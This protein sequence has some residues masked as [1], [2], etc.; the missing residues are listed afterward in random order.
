MEPTP[1]ATVVLARPAPAHSE[2]SGPEIL[3]MKRPASMQF[4]A[5]Y[6][7]FPGGALH[8]EDSSEAA[9]A[10]SVLSEAQAQERMG[11]GAGGVDALPFYV[12]AL[13]ELFEETG[14]L[15]AIGPPLGASELRLMRSRV[16][17]GE[18]FVKLL[19]D[20]EC[21]LSTDKIFYHSRWRAPAALPIRFDARVFVAE[22]KGEPLLGSEAELFEWRSCVEIMTLAE[23]GQMKLAP[24][25]AATVSSL[26]AH[27]T[28]ANMLAPRAGAPTLPPATRHSSLV[29]RFVAPNASLMT[30]PGTNTYIVGRD[31]LI[32]IDPGSMEPEHLARVGAAGRIAAVVVTHH[33]PDHIAGALELAESS[34]SEIAAS[35]PFWDRL[36]L[37]SAG[38]RLSTGDVIEVSGVK[39][40]VIE[41]PGHAS[42][43]ICLWLG[44]QRALFSGDLLLG[45]GTS[46]IS[47]PDGNLI[48]YMASLEK[49]RRL[50]PQRLY[51]G[52]FDPRDDAETWVAWYIAHRKE[53]EE[54]I[55]KLVS[56]MAKTPAELVA[57]IYESYPSQ[58]YPIAERSVAAHLDKLIAEHRVARAGKS[59]FKI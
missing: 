41:T 55:L 39:L 49:V 14:L 10:L 44:A 58:L 21:R 9:A 43:H 35:G 48:D 42:D 1:A 30:G 54:Q 47:P 59:Y 29:A 40:E 38:R 5:G 36:S 18:S 22:G 15:L 52:H 25:T 46:V 4:L 11:D 26:M 33:H 12:C 2:G 34:G 32:V 53:R 13:R 37:T 27:R 3:L 8:E 7:V 56:E 31:E 51:P 23:A 24:P 16:H 45:E 17:K 6:H 28:L 20:A 57:V 19:A 50:M